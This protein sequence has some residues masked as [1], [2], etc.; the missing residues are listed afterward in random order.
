ME[1]TTS[2]KGNQILIFN[3]YRFYK[4]RDNKSS[5]VWICAAKP[6]AGKVILKNRELIKEVDHD[7]VPDVASVEVFKAASMARKRAREENNTSVSQVR[8]IHITFLL[9]LFIYFLQAIL[10]TKYRK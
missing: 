7:C 6:C 3:G 8:M 1:F 10:L 4:K 5:E 9:L 2:I